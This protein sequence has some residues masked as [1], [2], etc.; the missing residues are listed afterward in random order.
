MTDRVLL[1]RKPAAKV[2]RPRMRDFGGPLEPINGGV[3]QNLQRLG[4]RFGLVLTPPRMRAE[5]FGRVWAGKLMMAKLYG[6]AYPFTQDG[7]RSRAGGVPRV[8]GDGHSGTT[9][10][11][12]GLDPG[13]YLAFGEAIS[14]V[15]AGRRYLHFVASGQV[16]PTG[17]GTL[18]IFPMLRVLPIDGDR[19]EYG[20]GVT[21]E[22]SISGNEIAWE[23]PSD[24][25]FDFGAITITEDA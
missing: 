1:P 16:Y 18:D 25:Y 17:S 20:A 9:I 12:R 22:G 10:A 19:I 8:D 14:L 11:I 3:V 6:A 15:H 4:T 7:F 13:S 5:P 23:R 21:I 24:G 2:D